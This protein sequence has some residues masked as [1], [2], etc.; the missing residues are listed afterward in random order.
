MTF[1]GWYQRP[2]ANRS[3]LTPPLTD[4]GR[5]R[6]EVFV[7]DV[8]ALLRLLMSARPSINWM[9]RMSMLS[10]RAGRPASSAALRRPVESEEPVTRREK[11]ASRPSWVS[12]ATR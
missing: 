8:Q 2:R 10:A 11:Y 12:P 6:S 1:P 7:R 3:E 5:C 4:S 9:V